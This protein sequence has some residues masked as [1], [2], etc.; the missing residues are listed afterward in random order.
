MGKRILHVSPEVLIEALKLHSSQQWRTTIA[1]ALPADA[2]FVS[3]VWAGESRTIAIMVESETW[4]GEADTP[5]P[6]PILQLEE[7]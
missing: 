1:N 5:L 2:R 6:L 3:A 4:Q 7:R